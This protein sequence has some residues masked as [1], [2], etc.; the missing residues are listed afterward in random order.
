[1][2]KEKQRL[3]LPEWKNW[4]PY[5]SNR[6][7]GTVREDYS[8]NGDAWHFTTYEMGISKAWR[9]GEDAI[10]G[11][12]DKEQ[13]LCFAPAFWNGKDPIIKERFFGL[14]NTEGNHGEDVKELFYYLDSTP[15]HSYMEMLYKYPQAAFP[16]QQLRNLN[17]N[18]TIHEPEYELIDTGI[19][20]DNRY[21]DIFIEYAK[22]DSEDILIKITVHN[23]GAEA[24]TLTVLPTLWFRNRWDWGR[25]NVQPTISVSQANKIDLNQKTLGNWF[26]YYE[27]N[28]KLLFCDNATNN[29]KLYN[30]PNKTPYTKDAVNEYIVHSNTDAV[31]PDETGTKVA[32]QYALAIAGQESATIRLRLKNAEDA[33]PFGD[34]DTLFQERKQEADMFYDEV[35]KWI[36]DEDERLIQRQAFAGLLWNKQF[37]YYNVPRW[38]QGDPDNPPPPPGHRTSRNAQWT[39][40]DNRD[41]I[42]VPDK[43]EFPWYAC[44]DSAFHCVAFVLIDAE[45]AKEQLM[46]FTR[47]WYMHP[48]G[49]LPAYEWNFSDTNPPVHAWAALEVYRIDALLNDGDGDGDFLESVFHK[50]LFNFTW[51]VNRK[52]HDGSNIFA[53]GF[54]GL[55]NIGVFDRSTELPNGARMEQSDGTSWMAMYA[56]NMLR[57]SL[58]LANGNSVY[59]DLASK[60]FE[61]FLYIAGALM[62]TLGI[63][64]TGLWDEQD[65]FFYDQIKIPDQTP[66][67][68]RLKSLVGL[69]PLLAVEVIDDD[70]LLKQPEFAFRM[71][72]FL[73]HREDLANLVS[74]WDEK[75]SDEKHLL[76]LLRGHR[77]KRLLSRMLNPHEFLSDFG[78]RSLSREYLAYP[79]ELNIGGNNISVTYTP[80]ESTD[81]IFGGNSNWRGPIWF[82]LNYM[83]IESLLHFYQYYSD[84]FKVE[85]PT[86]SAQYTD[87]KSIAIDLAERLI[88][89][90]K[91]DDNGRRTIYGDN[92]FQDDVH[93]QNLITFNE[94][95]NG[96]NGKGLG[97][98]HQTGWSALVSNLIAIKSFATHGVTPL[99]SITCRSGRNRIKPNTM[100]GKYREK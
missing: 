86:N 61:H 13:L 67:V 37:Y 89:I 90:F 82:P 17:K 95:F 69:I 97:A 33:N 25:N 11:I 60:F 83:L 40:I 3:E 30:S 19:L 38:Q 75:G 94:Y 47:E 45:F 21:F 62:N 35:Q 29:Q 92:R 57:I 99:K 48:N 10:G 65:E 81:G 2:N 28:H 24:A 23:R 31:N 70:T 84:D 46:L 73:N 79:Y 22:A 12:C 80:A 91:K 32:I 100:N 87:L 50:L 66:I 26:L 41:I 27:D 42:S 59:S 7:W 85:Y 20:D 76:S 54:L 93:F 14:N 96:D 72:W 8:D 39:N 53:G 4:G 9:W 78:I 16:Y 36:T 44:W 63:K 5:V 6:Q 58:E 15:T 1:M 43:W 64:D 51:W 52:D 56:L 71:R 88:N 55:D 74:R 34:F 18:R 68:I 77:T 98:S 49:Q